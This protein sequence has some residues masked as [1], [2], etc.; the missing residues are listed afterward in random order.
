[1]YFFKNEFIA[2][3]QSEA[4][5]RQPRNPTVSFSKENRLPTDGELRA[6]PPTPTPRAASK[7]IKLSRSRRL[8]LFAISFF[9]SVS[10]YLYLGHPRRALVWTLLSLALISAWVFAPAMIVERPASIYLLLIG[11]CVVALAPPVDLIGLAARGRARSGRPYQRQWVYL[12]LPLAMCLGTVAIDGSQAQD[13]VSIRTFYVPSGSMEPGL[14]VGDYLVSAMNPWRS[15]PLRRGD[16]VHLMW[17]GA[18]YLKRV[19]GL[20]GDKITLR[21][22]RVILNDA[23]LER[24]EIGPWAGHDHDFFGAPAHGRLY[25]ET[26]PEGRS[27]QI[28]KTLDDRGYFDNLPAVVVTPDHVFVLGDNRDNSNDSRAQDFGQIPLADIKGRPLVIYW[29]ADLARIGTRPQ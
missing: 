3:K 9:W 25:R 14:L 29:S 1:L 15:Q 23:P 2:L 17:N 19:I 7:S 20:P 16:L 6:Q 10:V 5:V 24:V 18:Y 11:I 22:G 8:G 4:A 27:Y 26:L 12:G 21:Q 13:A 28:G